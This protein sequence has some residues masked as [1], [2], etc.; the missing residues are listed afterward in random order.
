MGDEERKVVGEI[1]ASGMAVAQ[2][3]AT[4]GRMGTTKAY[5]I[6]N[7][8]RENDPSAF[9]AGEEAARRPGGG[10]WFERVRAAIAAARAEGVGDGAH[11]NVAA[12]FDAQENDTAGDAGSRDDETPG[13]DEATTTP[14]AMVAVRP[15]A[16]RLPTAVA[17]AYRSAAT[18]SFALVDASELLAPAPTSR[19][20]PAITV[21]AMGVTVTLPAG[22]AA[23]DVAAAVSATLAALGVGR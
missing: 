5:R 4:T 13:D 17:S 2:W 20:S 1:V 8:F 12:G 16:T 7:W 3:C 9:G 6:L 14:E 10:A 11:G 15:G 23:P 21:E 19:A 22:S 18:G